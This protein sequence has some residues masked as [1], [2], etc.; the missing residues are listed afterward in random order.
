MQAAVPKWFET[1][2]NRADI[3][4]QSILRS[5]Q[6]CFNGTNALLFGRG[7]QQAVQCLEDAKMRVTI[8]NAPFQRFCFI[9]LDEN[10]ILLLKLMYDAE[11]YQ[12]LLAVL[13]EDLQQKEEQP[14]IIQDGY[15]QNGHPTL[16]CVD[17]DLK[18]LIQFQ[19]QLSYL[20]VQGEVICFDFQKE[21]I[22]K[23]CGEQTK[24]STVNLETVRKNFLADK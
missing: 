3:L 21:A 18:R 5:K 20:G 15:N 1:V 23:Y 22:E 17:C 12:S 24:I 8:L 11:A 16:I 4:I 13:A 9:P 14:F 19:T 6:L 7:M 2:E 10:G